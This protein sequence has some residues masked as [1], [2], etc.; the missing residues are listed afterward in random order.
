MKSDKESM[1]CKHRSKMH[2]QIQKTII[3]FRRKFVNVVMQKLLQKHLALN[4]CMVWTNFWKNKKKYK[5]YQ[6]VRKKNN[7]NP[8]LNFSPA[9]CKL[10]ILSRTR[11]SNFTLETNPSQKQ[12][13]KAQGPRTVSY[14]QTK[15]YAMVLVFHDNNKRR[16]QFKADSN[17]I[18]HL[19]LQ[20][21][22]QQMMN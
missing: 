15:S 2:N 3:K 17:G 13:H 1:L 18:N 8:E 6:K 20:I 21:K 22:Q 19:S 5:K 10:I 11:F 12:L 16:S 14:L 4:G 7:V 9:E